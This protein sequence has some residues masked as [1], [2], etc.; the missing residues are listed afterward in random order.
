[1]VM[2]DYY[3]TLVSVETCLRH[4]AAAGWC[5]I[6]CRVD[7]A[8]NAWGVQAY[9]EAHIPG[10][11]YASLEGEL[12]GAPSAASGRH[13]LP[14]WHDFAD[15]L[16]RWGVHPDT[17]VVVYDQGGG[18]FAARLWWL[19]RVV[20]HSRVA[21]LDGGWAAWQAA[22]GAESDA[23]APVHAQR[24][25][26]APGTGWVTTEQVEQNLHSREFVLVDARSSE[27]FAG[28][29]EPIDPVAGHIPGALNFPFEQNLDASGV[30]LAPAELRQRWCE[31][32]Q[33]YAGSTVVHMCGSGVTACHNLLA[34]EVAG[35]YDS[36]LYVG[37]WSEWIRG[38]ARP[39]A[40]GRG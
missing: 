8:D 31:S 3:D 18:A 10:A 5:L 17:Q 38:A 34:M 20:G 12:A 14:D 2:T 35:L 4:S 39:V 36:R 30:F 23:A 40:T 6:D 15:S 24:V 32:L 33:E 16:G 1:M 25:A 21:V 28:E 22:G 19:L 7:L 27:R 26:L 13:P 11:H 29:R 37:S 9:R